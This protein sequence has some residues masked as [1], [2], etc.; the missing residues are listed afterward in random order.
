MKQTRYRLAF[1]LTI[2]AALLLAGVARSQTISVTPAR[3]T[4]VYAIGEPIVW[5]VVVPDADR[6]AITSAH[7]QVRYAG[8]KIVAEGDVDL[9][10]GAAQVRYT[11]T[12]PAAYLL[13]VSTKLDGG[14][15][16]SAD[17]GA[18]ADPDRIT[19]SLPRPADFDSFWQEKLAELRAIDP[20]PAV[21]RSD[22]GIPGIVYETAT[23]ANIDG[24]RVHIQMA[25]PEGGKDL[26]A[27]LILQWAG[28]YGLKKSSVTDP[29]AQGWLAV[30]VMAHDLDLN[31][32]DSYYQTAAAT[33]LKNYIA[34]GNADRNTSY[35]LKMV[36]GD[37]RAADYVATRPEWDGKTMIATGAS[38][39]GFQSIA[40]A[41]L[42]PQIKAIMTL[43]P[44]G[45]DVDGAVAG[46]A[47]PWPYW[48]AAST[49]PNAA[50]VQETSRY[51]DA[52]N[53][54]SD[55]HV[56]ALVAIGLIDRTATPTGDLAMFNQLA[57]PKE[58]VLLPLSNHHGDGKAQGPYYPRLNRWLQALRDGQPVPPPS[59]K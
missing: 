41:A 37:V 42:D 25:Y 51:Y 2:A 15:I 54:A 56:P 57:G 55:V 46:R 27:Q 21:E 36:L 58:L 22:S 39:G 45:C 38:Q 30:N 35:F 31:M 33:T 59:G 52:V 34:I 20:A 29:A 6:A 8:G 40:L 19:P 26:P 17:G 50:A 32:P 43:V 44:A 16:V 1:A 48:T 47:T 13:T 49:S 24:A 53:F 3:E 10:S 23:L 18:A 7:Y 9:S 14:K 4:G 11:P 12:Q 5:Q 28:V